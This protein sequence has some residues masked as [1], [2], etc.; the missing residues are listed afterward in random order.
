MAAVHSSLQCIRSRSLRS[1]DRVLDR[2]AG[3]L[4]ND[5]VAQLREDGEMSRKLVLNVTEKRLKA[6]AE[7][8]LGY[9]ALNLAYL[10]L[11]RAHRCADVDA[12]TRL[13]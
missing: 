4:G 9:G 7:G 12:L 6:R 3:L 5:A 10:R 1:I 2:I 13:A 11:I 8:V